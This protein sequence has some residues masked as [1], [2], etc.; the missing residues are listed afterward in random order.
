MASVGGRNT[1]FAWF[2]GVVCAAVVI[3]MIVVALPLFPATSGWFAGAFTEVQRFFDPDAA[4]PAPEPSET[5]VD[6]AAFDECRDL[7]DDA[8]WASMRWTSGAELVASTDA[9]QSSATALVDALLPEVSMTCTWTADVGSVSTT[10]ASVPTDAG[11]IAASA[12]PTVGFACDVRD[13]RTLCTRT[14][15]DLVETIETGGGLWVSTSEDAWH[16]SGH[17]RRVA[18]AA[19]AAQD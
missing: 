2:V 17:A 18:E 4:P 7:Y 12:L 14:D 13:S 1:V 3:A 6:P 19:W 15:G 9:P 11:A 10:V 16:P 5:P 8:L